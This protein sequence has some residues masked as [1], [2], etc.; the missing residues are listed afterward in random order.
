[1]D[2]PPESAEMLLF[3]M[4]AQDRFLFAELVKSFQ[5]HMTPGEKSLCQR[6]LLSMKSDFIISEETEEKE[7]AVSE[8]SPFVPD[9]EGTRE[10]AE[11]SK[12]RE[13]YQPE[14]K[15]PEGVIKPAKKK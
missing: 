7:S 6:M 2:K 3:M 15:N 11:A 5:K 12:K 14:P 1:M 9:P 10:K 4:S 8:D 13:P